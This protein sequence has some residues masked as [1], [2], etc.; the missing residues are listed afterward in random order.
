MVDWSRFT[1]SD[2]EYDFGSDKLV[3]HRVSFEEAVE[4]FFRTLRSG[5]TKHMP[6]GINSSAVHWAEEGS[7][8]SFSLSRAI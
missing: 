5:A 4:C 1:P 3:A 8:S 2:F 6:I 7:R